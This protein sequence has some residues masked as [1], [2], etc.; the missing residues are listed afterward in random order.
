MFVYIMSY[1]DREEEATPMFV[2]TS[3]QDCYNYIRH[4]DYREYPEVEIRCNQ[5]DQ[6]GAEMPVWC[7]SAY[8]L[9]VASKK[10]GICNYLIKKMVVGQWA[11]KF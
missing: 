1:A 11:Y 4:Y 9:T 6:Q 10:Y 8:Y 3:I 5:L 2:G 7:E